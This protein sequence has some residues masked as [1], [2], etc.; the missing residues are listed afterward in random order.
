[1]TFLSSSAGVPHVTVPPGEGELDDAGRPIGEREASLGIMPEAV[2]SLSIT[3]AERAFR[4][5]LAILL[6]DEEEEG[7]T[8]AE[9]SDLDRFGPTGSGPGAGGSGGPPRKFLG[10]GIP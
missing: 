6:G 2:K 4:R 9:A 3:P 1:M 10:G 7:C 8:S 5:L